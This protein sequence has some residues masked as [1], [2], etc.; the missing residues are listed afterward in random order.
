M[1]SGSE[2][3]VMG[4][5]L[6][7]GTKLLHIRL[8]ARVLVASSSLMLLHVRAVALFKRQNISAG[9]VRKELNEIEIKYLLMDIETC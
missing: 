2:R 1:S 5:F 3:K 9:E 6:L 7:L 8:K 4:F